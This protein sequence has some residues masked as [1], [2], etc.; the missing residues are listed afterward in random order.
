[1]MID[2]E[3]EMK[4]WVINTIIESLNINE[5]YEQIHNLILKREEI[6]K[7]MYENMGL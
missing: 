6:R 1:M 2:K 5:D 4:E 3:L 7:K